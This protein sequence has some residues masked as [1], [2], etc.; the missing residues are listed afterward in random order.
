MNIYSEVCWVMPT[1]RESHSRLDFMTR[2]HHRV[3]DFVV[4]ELPRK[5]I[6]L[7]PAYIAETLNLA[8]VRVVE[9]LDD[10]EKHM[11]FLFRN[12]EGAVTWA[13][14]VTVEKTPHRV[15]FKS[16]EQIYAAWGVDAIATPFVQGQLRKEHLD[17]LIETECAC[18]GQQIHIQIDS[19]LEYQVQEKDASPLIFVPIVDFDTLEDPSIVDAFWR[20]SVFFWSEE[21]AKEFSLKSNMVQGTLMT[22]EQTVSRTPISQG[23]LFAFPREMPG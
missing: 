6:A 16:G 12:A 18:C 23:A 15:T 14:P 3:R 7:T 4:L 11:T 19:D 20:N 1:K 13:Y 5:G 8:Y 2:D 10:L 9:I 21:H 17:L 22:L